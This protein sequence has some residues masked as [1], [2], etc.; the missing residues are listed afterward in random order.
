MRFTEI[1]NPEDQLALWRL[2]SDKMWAAFG[3]QPTQQVYPVTTQPV[4]NVNTKEPAK[5]ISGSSAKPQSRQKAIPVKARKP[6]KPPFAPLPKAL[7]KPKPQQAPQSQNKNIQIKQQPSQLMQLPLMKKSQ[8]RAS[9]S[10]QS[11]EVKSDQ[12]MPDTPVNNS[13]SERDKDE[14]VFHS[15][16]ENPF[17]TVSQT[18][19]GITSHKPSL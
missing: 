3:Q 1:A 14:L 12:V 6:K 19:N 15:R 8:V 11:L 4:V 18:Q 10:P 9:L 17:K 13:Y 16:A 5:S 2:V 7:P